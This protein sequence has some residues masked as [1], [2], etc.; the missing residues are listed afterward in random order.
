MVESRMEE[1]T[2]NRFH[3]AL[4]FPGEHRDFVLKVAEALATRLTRERV[5]YDEWY[6]AELL[7]A[8]G[9][10]KLQSMYKQA[11]L[12]IPFFSEYYSKSWCSLEWETIRGILL[13]RRR[14]DAVIPVH[15]D[16]TDIPGWSEVNFGIR[17]RDRTPQ[18]ISDLILEAFAIRNFK[19]QRQQDNTITT[20]VE[21][22]SEKGVDYSKLRNLLASEKWREADQ[23]TADRMLGIIGKDCWQSIE[24]ED[25]DN[26]SCTDLKTINKLW[27]NYSQGKFG[28][29]VQKNIYKDLNRIKECEDDIWE[30]FIASVGWRRADDWLEYHSINLNT[31]PSGYLPSYFFP[32]SL[33]FFFFNC[34]QSN[35]EI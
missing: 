15:L 9:D 20:E 25:I 3:I 33:R 26:F 5:F 23:E 8:G 30:R 27:L 16:G 28:F 11:D 18:K 35:R 32:S 22:K 14:E 7:G 34:L 17:L 29:S 21:L 24:K 10:L 12:V 31:V 1:Q 19:N 2:S 4:S 6:E 13:N